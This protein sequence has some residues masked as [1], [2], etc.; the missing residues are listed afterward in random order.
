MDNKEMEKLNA[1]ELDQVAG[2]NGSLWRKHV[3]KAQICPHTNKT[4]T[5]REKED[6]FLI[7]WSIHKYEYCCPDCGLNIWLPE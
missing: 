2:G 3:K 1:E 6:S 5:G 7:F 4:R